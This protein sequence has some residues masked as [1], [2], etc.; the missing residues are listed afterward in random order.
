L[1]SKNRKK[2]DDKFKADLYDYC[3]KFSGLSSYKGVV[4]RRTADIYY[5]AVRH[6]G[7][8]RV[9]GVKL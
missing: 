2:I 4:C 5:K 8:G 9:F 7:D 6:A 1:S 3:K